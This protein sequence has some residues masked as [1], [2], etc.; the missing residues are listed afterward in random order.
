MWRGQKGTLPA[1]LSCQGEKSASLS[2]CIS[3][4]F[5]LPL[6]A[7]PIETKKA[8]LLLEVSLMSG[9]NFCNQGMM[10]QQPTKHFSLQQNNNFK[11]LHIPGCAL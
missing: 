11:A 6:T 9:F 2:L 8:L 7:A 1:R 5:L 4:S 10:K 3:P